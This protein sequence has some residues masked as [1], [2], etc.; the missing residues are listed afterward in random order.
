MGLD[1][2]SMSLVKILRQSE[3]F[4]HALTKPGAARSAVMVLLAVC[5]LC[6]QK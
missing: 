6:S 1:G 5:E 3:N 4:I 2:I